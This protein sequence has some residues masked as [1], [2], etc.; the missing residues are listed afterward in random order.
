MGEIASVQE[1]A[2]HVALFTSGGAY[3]GSAFEGLPLEKRLEWFQSDRERSLRGMPKSARANALTH[4]LEALHLE[5]VE[6]AACHRNGNWTWNESIFKLVPEC[7]QFWIEGALALAIRRRKC[8]DDEWVLDTFDSRVE[9]LITHTWVPSVAM[10]VSQLFVILV[11]LFDSGYWFGETDT[12]KWLPLLQP[13]PHVRDYTHLILSNTLSAEFFSSFPTNPFPLVDRETRSILVTL[14]KMCQVA[15]QYKDDGSRVEK[16][17]FPTTPR[18]V[19][20]DLCVYETCDLE[21]LCMLYCSLVAISEVTGDRGLYNPLVPDRL[22][23][24][25]PFSG[26]IVRSLS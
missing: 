18:R 1:H 2:E 13:T 12:A 16:I 6:D 4:Y 7:N 8:S 20:D 11:E 19:F 10:K 22:A 23:L 26:R 15:T 14:V 9:D 21:L 5:T 25:N 3:V 17:D 24:S